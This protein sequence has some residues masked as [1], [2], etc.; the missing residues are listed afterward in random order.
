MSAQITEEQVA[1]FLKLPAPAV[2]RLFDEKVLT[3]F[4]TSETW[5]TTRTLLEQDIAIFTEDAK[6]RRLRERGP[7]FLPASADGPA[8]EVDVERIDL[9]DALKR[10][11][12]DPGPP[13]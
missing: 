10:M 7:S 8:Q 1:E 6:A 3:G 11:G 9:G 13:R 2:R 5:H 12:D 4:R